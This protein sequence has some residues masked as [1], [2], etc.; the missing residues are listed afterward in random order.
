MTTENSYWI[1]DTEGVYALVD[2]VDIRD[3]WTKVRGWE[4]APVPSATDQVHVVNDN[5]EI[6]PG[7]LPYGALEGW[8][9]R[10][11]RA[12][13]PAELSGLT[14]DPAPAPAVAEPVITPAAAGE[15]ET[16]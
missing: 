14:H 12:G 8:A 16:E 5:P 9:G 13:P 7:R 11:F 15:Q 1:R 6:G 3:E 2:G 4:L 10:G